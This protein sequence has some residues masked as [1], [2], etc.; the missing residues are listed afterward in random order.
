MRVSKDLKAAV[1]VNKLMMN[2]LTCI[3][4]VYGNLMNFY[5]QCLYNPC[6][7]KAV[8][9]NESPG[10]SCTTCPFG[11]IGDEVRGV[12]VEFAKNNKQVTINFFYLLQMNLK[13]LQC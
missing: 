2:F 6:F 8:C 13:Y 10:Y 3:H 1:R 7:E 12:G 11:Y 4:L 5:F 9:V